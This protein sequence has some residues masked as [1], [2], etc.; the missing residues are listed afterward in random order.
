MIKNKGFTLIEFLLVVS[1]VMVLS[2]GAIFSF[3]KM[4]EQGILDKEANKIRTLFVLGRDQ[5][6]QGKCQRAEVEFNSL[7]KKVVMKCLSNNQRSEIKEIKIEPNVKISLDLYLGNLNSSTQQTASFL[8]GL[9]NEYS[10]LQWLKFAYSSSGLGALSLVKLECNQANISSNYITD[11]L[12]ITIKL[13]KGGEEKIISLTKQS[14]LY[15][16]F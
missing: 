4:S 6:R 8:G 11:N 7:A 13:Q 10:D 3:H 16:N 9:Q 15:G 14:L 5:L 1:I 12:K 2:G